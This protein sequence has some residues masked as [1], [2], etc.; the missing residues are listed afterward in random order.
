MTGWKLYCAGWPSMK[1]DRDRFNDIYRRRQHLGDRYRLDNPGNR[2]NL[3]RL[4]EAMQEILSTVGRDISRI[5]LLDLGCGGLFWTE[6]LVRLGVSRERAFGMDLL[7]WR[8]REGHQSGRD[9]QAVNGSATAIPFGSESFD[10]V[11][12]FTLMTS[13]TDSSARRHIVEEMRRVLRPGGYVLWYDFR[14]NN[15]AN[16]HTRAIGRSEMRRLFEGWNMA[17]VPV[18]LIPQIARKIPSGLSPLLKFLYRLPILRSHY[19]ALI[20]PKG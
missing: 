18:T 19:V 1:S 16:P 8:M 10:L 5:R 7:H 20:G 6:E 3:E 13:V 9:I 14:Y 12:Q 4:R 11:C 17:V 2:F 15:P